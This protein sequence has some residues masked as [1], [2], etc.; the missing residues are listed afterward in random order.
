MH[1][2]QIMQKEKCYKNQPNH[3]KFKAFCSRSIRRASGLIYSNADSLILGDEPQTF[4]VKI[5][6]GREET[7]PSHGS[8]GQA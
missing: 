7:K 3:D 5:E 2:I 1:S 4:H 6:E 8:L